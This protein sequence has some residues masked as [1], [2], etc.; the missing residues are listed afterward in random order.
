MTGRADEARDS[1]D[2]MEALA[3]STSNKLFRDVALRERGMLHEQAGEYE[4]ALEHLQGIKSKIPSPVA[5]LMLED[6][7]EA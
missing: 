7:S 4:R 6:F 3:T 1:I 2:K 5:Y